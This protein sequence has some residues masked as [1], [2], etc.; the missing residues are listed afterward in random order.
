MGLRTFCLICLRLSSGGRPFGD[1]RRWRGGVAVSNQ[2][3]S[4]A[5]E[6]VIAVEAKEGRAAQDTRQEPGAPT[7]LVSG[8]RLIEVK[9]YGGSARG[10]DLWLEPAQ[11]KAALTFP[12]RFWLYVVDNVSQ[13]DAALFRLLRFGGDQWTGML[14]GRRERRYYEIPFPVGVYD[15]TV[16]KQST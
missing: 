15:E 11:V 2:V 16:G 1:E 4:V 3:E 9:A 14:A 13:G 7:D 12:D 6:F 8:D 5:I 10:K